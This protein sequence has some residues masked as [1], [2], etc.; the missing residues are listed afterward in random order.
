M[1]NTRGIHTL[2]REKEILDKFALQAG[3][4]EKSKERGGNSTIDYSGDIK[5]KVHFKDSESKEDVKKSERDLT[6]SLE[7]REKGGPLIPRHIYQTHKF[8]SHSIPP[9]MA[10]E[11]RKIKEMHKD[12]SYTYFDDR[13]AL[14]MMKR[15]YGVD[16]E[17][18]NAYLCLNNNAF[19]ADFWRY[20]L[21]YKRG[22]FYLDADLS[23]KIPID[24]FV[25]PQVT[26]V[27]PF[28][29]EEGSGL[30]NAFMGV[31]PNHPVMRMAMDRIMWNI[32]NQKKSVLS[33]LSFLPSLFPLIIFSPVFS[34]KVQGC[35]EIYWASRT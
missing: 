3:S 34:R 24:G 27:T 8:E 29:L 30:F 5:G 7:A 20:A 4:V 23:L 18:Y 25:G 31:I 19:R 16:S 11:M 12:F 1:P 28:C 33:F 35:V 26:F 14:M 22:G 17:E 13:E 10:A 2:K 15:E 9:K 21:L 6:K 32:V